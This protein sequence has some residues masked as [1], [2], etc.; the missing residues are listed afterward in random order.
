MNDEDPNLA[1]ALTRLALLVEEA[2]VRGE[3]EAMAAALATA[4]AAGVPSVRMVTVCGLT[5]SG[6][7]FFVNTGTGK[8][9]Q[10]QR[11]PHAGLCFHWPRLHYQ[12]LVEGLAAM[13]SV[14]ESERLWRG[15]PREVTLGHWASD[16]TQPAAANVKDEVRAHG[17]RF[18][19]GRVPL[20]PGWNA[21][22]LQPLRV[23]FWPTGW[24]R[25]RPRER[26]NKA[27]D[28][29]WTVSRENP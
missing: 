3:P 22:E 7:I 23:A 20:A 28:G 19:D 1:A 11:N 21:F 17:R 27:A 10:L 12:V 14:E 29:T 5:P 6:L 25:L 2:K 15:L 13:Q 8:G 24:H 4:S 9:Q 16:Q 18:A 26:Y